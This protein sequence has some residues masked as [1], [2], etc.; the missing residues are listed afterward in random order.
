MNIW[1]ILILAAIGI[2][3]FFALRTAVWNRKNCCGNCRG[4]EKC[5]G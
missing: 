3:L 2:V 1:D 4:C 5:G